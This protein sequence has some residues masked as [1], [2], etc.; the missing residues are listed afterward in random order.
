MAALALEFTPVRQRYRSVAEHPKYPGVWLP[1]SPA[2]SSMSSNTPST[3]EWFKAQTPSRLAYHPTHGSPCI[4]GADG[5][6]LRRLADRQ[7]LLE[8]RSMRLMEE[9]AQLRARQARLDERV[10]RIQEAEASWERREHVILGTPPPGAHGLPLES[11]PMS[12]ERVQAFDLRNRAI[13]R[14]RPLRSSL[15]RAAGQPTV[16]DVCW[17]YRR[18]GN[19]REGDRCPLF[20]GRVDTLGTGETPRRP[21]GEIPSSPRVTEGTSMRHLPVNRPWTRD[22]GARRISQSV[23]GWAA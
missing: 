20:H 12:A 23:N 15:D 13:A 11:S 8:K 14:S 4:G 21:D 2:A 1:C 6:A 16:A 3:E 17:E 19:C 5:P 7:Q 22:P 10:R 18:E 9:E